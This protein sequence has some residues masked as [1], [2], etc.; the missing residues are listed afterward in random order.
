MLSAII[1]LVNIHAD[2]H[3]NV[4]ALS[5]IMHS[6]ILLSVVVPYLLTKSAGVITKSDRHE[7]NTR[8]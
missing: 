8:R 5:V 4:D 6:V 1:M 2:G 3:I 7:H